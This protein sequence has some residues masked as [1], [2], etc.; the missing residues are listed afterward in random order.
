MAFFGKGDVEGE[1]GLLNAM[2][3]TEQSEGCGG[4]GGSPSAMEYVPSAGQWEG[5]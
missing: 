5:L 3:V 4:D 1:V 2:Q